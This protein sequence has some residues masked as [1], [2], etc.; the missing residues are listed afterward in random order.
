MKH[1]KL[2][3]SILIILLLTFSSCF[4]FFYTTSTRIINLCEV[5]TPKVSNEEERVSSDVSGVPL[6][7]DWDDTTNPSLPV[8]PDFHEIDEYGCHVSHLWVGPDDPAKTTSVHW[9]RI[10]TMPVNM[11][12]YLITSASVST[13]FNASVIT[14]PGG[15]D[16]PTDYCGVDTPNDNLP[17]GAIFDYV[18]FYILISDIENFEVYEIAYY[19]SVDLGQDNPEIANITDSFMNVI[20]KEVLIFFLTSLFKRDNFH[21]KITLGLDIYCEDNYLYDRDSWN[22]LRIKSCNLSFTYK[23]KITIITP[24]NKTYTEPMSGYYPATY[25]FESDKD[26]TIP[27]DWEEVKGDPSMLNEIIAELDGHKKVIHMDKGNTYGDNN[28]LNQYFKSVQEFGTIEFWAR[29]TDIDQES[30]WHL[31]SGSFNKYSIAGVRMMDSSF[32]FK[33]STVWYPVPY[34]AYNNQWYHISIQFECGTNNHYGLDQN[35][36][37]FF[38]NGVQ[39][40]DYQMISSHSNVSHII[41]HQN[42]RY[43]NFHM[44]T[45]AV[46]YSWDPNY[47]IGDNLNEGLLLS[48]ENTTSLDWKG[49]SLDGQ[50]NKTI[51]GNITIPMP[52]DGIHNIQV[53][54]N[55][56]IG[57]IYESNVRYFTIASNPRSN[58]G[59]QIPGYNLITLIGVVCIMTLFF[60]TK[61]HFLL[62]RE[63]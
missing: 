53:F 14:Q 60:L 17:Q 31:K 55:D 16:Y 34:A 2:K 4:G 63:N 21:F 41:I 37:R 32:Q 24:Q 28:N 11:I 12:N 35:K 10:I 5:D 58:G 15:A 23:N 56:S 20:D 3:F 43:D 18:R 61:I 45:D 42:W 51:L 47:S 52:F 46:S 50:T 38:I 33:N 57:T 7:S 27:E 1:L 30:A 62:R 9:E 49:Y 36:W 19:Q 48:Y 59:P 54:G 13:I 22:S 44:Y 40:G 26:G 39:F 25:G 6:N 8:L 29:T